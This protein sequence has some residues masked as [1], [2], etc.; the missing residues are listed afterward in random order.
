MHPTHSPL[1]HLTLLLV[2]ALAACRGPSPA[3]HFAETSPGSG[4]WVAIAAEPA[5]VTMPPPRRG[6][7]RRVVESRSNLSE[8]AVGN[9]QALAERE[10]AERVLVTLRTVV[11]SPEA[12][13]AAAAVPAAIRLVE[14]VRRDEVLTRD[15]VPGNTL[16]TA[17]GLYEVSI[18]DVVAPITEPHR[19]LARAALEKS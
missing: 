4:A 13:A 14:R 19:A 2:L 15:P 3:R 16:S 7:L 9:L 8:I 11:T 6:H 10:V 5:W 1:R 18:G 17:F 12:A